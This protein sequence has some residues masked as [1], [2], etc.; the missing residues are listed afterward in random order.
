MTLSKQLLLIT[1][2]LFIFIVSGCSKNLQPELDDLEYPEPDAGSV[3]EKK[4]EIVEF[5]IDEDVGDVDTSSSSEDS[6]KEG[7]DLLR[8][9]DPVYPEPFLLKHDDNRVSLLTPEEE[10]RRRLEY[11]SS[12][13]LFDMFFDFDMYDLDEKL[14][15]VLQKNVKYL[16]SHP[17]SKIVIQGHCDERGSNNY[18]LSLGNQRAH[19]VKSFLITLGVD[20]SKIHTVSYG[21]EKPF[22]FEDNENCWHQN[23]RV[24]FL[25]AE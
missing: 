8:E 16:E 18:N 23:R 20:E 6:R 11:H 21:E 10:A 24:R 25:V 15:T 5:M 19:S 22:C 12:D 4:E 13:Q 17:Y 7:N 1:P 3:T 14:L 2:I 9:G